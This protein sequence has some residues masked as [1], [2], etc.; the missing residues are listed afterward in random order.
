M[1]SFSSVLLKNTETIIVTFDGLVS[2]AISNYA[3]NL[4][5][6]DFSI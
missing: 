4:K 6:T 1:Q 5:L 2:L 3:Q